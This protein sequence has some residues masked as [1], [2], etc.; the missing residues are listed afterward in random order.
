MN[1]GTIK[2]GA[3]RYIRSKFAEIELENGD[4]YF[5]KQEGLSY[6]IYDNRGDKYLESKIIGPPIL[7]WFGFGEVVFFSENKEILK[8]QRSV[9]IKYEGKE[10]RDRYRVDRD[11][12]IYCTDEF[13][14]Y[15][16]MRKG[17]IVFCYQD[18]HLG[19]CLS[20]GVYYWNKYWNSFS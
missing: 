3:K 7:R 8:I 2:K 16:N 4:L 15:I 12:W 13:E 1:K 18:G 11:A 19:I 17:E 5:F 10:Y 14:L 6:N 9:K 20:C